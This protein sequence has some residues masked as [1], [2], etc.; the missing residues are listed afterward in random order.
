MRL[1]LQW[2]DR[3]VS[4]ELLTTIFN[5]LSVHLRQPSEIELV[6][7]RV[8][9]VIGELPLVQRREE[10]EEEQPAGEKKGLRHFLVS[11]SIFGGVFG[12]AVGKLL[13]KL[14][15]GANFNRWATPM[16]LVLCSLLRHYQSNLCFVDQAVI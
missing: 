4:V 11:D 13:Y 10:G 15:R 8:K 9:E 7:A 6:I 5:E 2:L 1:I 12:R 16:L 3:I 14:R